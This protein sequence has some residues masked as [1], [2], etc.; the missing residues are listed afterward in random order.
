MKKILFALAALLSLAA[1]NSNE[2]APATDGKA[3]VESI[4][5]RT[6]IRDYTDQAISAD[7]VET[8]LRAGMAA[9]SAVNKQPW[10]FIVVNKKEKL[11]ELASTN[12]YAKMLEKAP[13]L[14]QHGACGCCQR[15][16]ESDRQHHSPLHRRHRLSR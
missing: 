5:T 14:S 3:I 12:P 4:M 8:L 11:M 13:A 7:T 1:C 2:P 16:A 10:H 9:P 15:G 6:S